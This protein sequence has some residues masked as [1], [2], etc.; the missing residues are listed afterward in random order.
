MIV[1]LIRFGIVGVIAAVLDVGVLVILKELLH[2][3]VLLA[4]MI[5]F[6]V[7]VTA[8]YILSMAFVFKSKNQNKIKE[9]IVFVLLSIGGLC[10]N[11]LILWIGVNFTSV[12][13]L[14]VKFIAMVIVP[15]Y[16]FITRK[17][18]LEEK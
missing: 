6:C 16:N 3:D 8:N 18:F 14:V 7:S 17:I 13:Y 15:V 5:S 12:Y 9:F 4:S 2:M 11:Q 1:Q 10:L